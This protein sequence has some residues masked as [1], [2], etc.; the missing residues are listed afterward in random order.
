MAL[1]RAGAAALLVAAGAAGCDGSGDLGTV[2]IQIVDGEV[3]CENGVCTDPYGEPVDADTSLVEQMLG[4]RYVPVIAS[5]GVEGGTILNVNADVMAG[6]IAAA[7]KAELVIAGGTRG[8]LDADGLPNAR[9]VLLKGADERGFVFY[10]N[11]DSQKGQELGAQPQAA[12][13]FYWKSSNRQVRV[14]GTVEQGTDAE[15]DAYFASR[16][17]GARR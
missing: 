13:V 11:M 2:D 3:E 15:A 17:L 8:V 1:L 12:L 7:L 10:T 9:M 4:P 6:R 14:R 5:L 16:P